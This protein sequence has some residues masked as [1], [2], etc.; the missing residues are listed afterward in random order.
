MVGILLLILK[1]V[2]IILGIILAVVLFLL[3][4]VL[5]VP[6]S[7]QVTGSKDN[8]MFA[9]GKASWLFRVIQVGFCYQNDIHVNA[10]VFWKTIYS[11]Q[12]NQTAPNI[13]RRK[14]QAKVLEPNIS[15]ISRREDANNIDEKIFKTDHSFQKMKKEEVKR[16]VKISGRETEVLERHDSKEKAEK[17]IK[18]KPKREKNIKV[19]KKRT[20][21]E[22]KSNVLKEAFEK[23][24]VFFSQDTYKG[25][26]KF[27]AK[28]SWKIIKAILPKRVRLHLEFG[29]HD[30]AITGY[31]LGFISIFYAFTGNS[32]DIKPDFDK[33]LLKGKLDIKGRIFIFILVYHGLRIILDKR[34]KKLIAE[35]NH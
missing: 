5:F 23:I 9:E 34:V 35:Y 24:R 22:K 17:K 31:I 10:K 3:A 33:Q 13:K 1:I 28:H 16:E 27:V 29:T 32:M 14:N 2:L 8:A 4:I 11:S 26:L 25:V 15:N 12:D 20:N 6:I 7:Y 18:G 30:P 19:E 21:T